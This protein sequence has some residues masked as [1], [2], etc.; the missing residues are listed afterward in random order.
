VRSMSTYGTEFKLNFSPTGYKVAGVAHSTLVTTEEMAA[1]LSDPSWAIVDCR[2]NLTDEAW[3]EQQ[4]QDA[5][6]PGAV[7]ASLGR[8]LSGPSDGRNGRHPLPGHEAMAEAFG[9]FGVRPDVQVVAYDQDTGMYASR[10]W[11]MLRYMGHDAVAVLDGGMARWIREGRPTRGGV[12]ARE[13]AT[14]TG[15]PRPAMRLSANQVWAK[16]GDP[17]MTLVD[18]RAPARYEGKEEPLDR[19]AGHI[20]GARNHFFQWNLGPDGSFLAPAAL[21]EKFTA[22]LGATPPEHLALYCGSGVTACH[23]MLAMERA[24]LIGMKLF[25]G[26]WSEWSADPDK[27]VETGPFAKP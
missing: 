12:E 22:L 11:W 21:R 26:S 20:P 13:P 7:Y 1:H 2:Y 4:Y 23:N 10:L 15:K 27:P 6:I 3:G 9:R 14:F 19:V 24:G 5:H 8:N 25:P 16:L 18:A 17:S